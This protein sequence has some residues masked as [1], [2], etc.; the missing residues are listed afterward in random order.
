MGIN[1]F[2]RKELVKK[3]LKQINI[4]ATLIILVSII[5]FFIFLSFAFND[6]IIALGEVLWFLIVCWE[7]IPIAIASSYLCATSLIYKEI[8]GRFG[9]YLAT[10]IIG[11]LI[12]G[13]TGWIIAVILKDPLRRRLYRRLEKHFEKQWVSLDAND[14]LILGYDYSS[15]RNGKMRSEHLAINCFIKAAELN[16]PK[17]YLELGFFEEDS[18]NYESARNLYLK[19]FTLGDEKGAYYMARTFEKCHFLSQN[20]EE[21]FDWYKKGADANEPLCQYYLG[22]AYLNGKAVTKNEQLGLQFM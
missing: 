14:F 15:G 19:A 5:Y 10:L 22:L 3:W 7:V 8:T 6:N 21:A 18:G 2:S 9:S 1:W 17:A 11:I 12:S 16:H 20:E 4:I 13:F